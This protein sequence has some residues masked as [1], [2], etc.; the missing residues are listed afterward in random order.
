MNSKARKIAVVTNMPSYHQVD[1]FNR[2]SELPSIELHVFYLRELTPGRQWIELKEINHQHTFVREHRIHNHF[3]LNTGFFRTVKCFEPDLI[4]ITQYAS[5]AMQGMMYYAMIRRIPWIFW[6]ERPGVEW[7]ELPIFNSNLLRKVFRKAAL[8]PVK[9]ATAVWGIG[10]RATSY[11]QSMSPRSCKNL[12]YYSDIRP[13]L[14][15]I[16]NDLSEPIKFLYAGKFNIRKGFDVL[17]DSIDIIMGQGRQ[18][19]FTFVGD[20][21][22]KHKLMELVS[23][24]SPHV[25]Y[26][27]FKEIREMPSIFAKC[28][29]LLCPS[30]YD[31][32]GMVVAEGMAAG[33]PVIS[34]TNTGAAIDM[35]INKINGLILENLNTDEIAKAINYFISNPQSIPRMREEARKISLRYHV[36][37]G[38]KNFLRY[39]DDVY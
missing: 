16:R 12:P 5:I 34:T 2:L 32:W 6:S 28:D 29:V 9:K 31:G 25:E 20:G 39:V 18:A 35:I 14:D 13:F 4:I 11:F 7:T 21:P 36:E 26:I 8:I 22:L 30:R 10:K 33:M 1:F 27:G 17:V 37:V 15:I 3:Y 38:A 19:K 24:Y 23:K